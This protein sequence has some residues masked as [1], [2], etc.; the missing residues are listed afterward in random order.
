MEQLRRMMPSNAGGDFADQEDFDYDEEM[1]LA[2]ALEG[3]E[4]REK[5]LIEND[6]FKNF[7]DDFDDSVV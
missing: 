1:M 2:S 4:A 7:E 6:F 5:N 3:G